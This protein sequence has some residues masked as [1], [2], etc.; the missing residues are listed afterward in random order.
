MVA[1]MALMQALFV[2]HYAKIQIRNQVSTYIRI[3]DG[4]MKHTYSNFL[5]SKGSFVRFFWMYIGLPYTT[6]SP[7]KVIG[8]SWNHF[9]SGLPGDP[10]GSICLCYEL[11]MINDSSFSS[12]TILVAFTYQFSLPFQ[13]QA[14]SKVYQTRKND[15]L[16]HHNTSIVLAHLGARNER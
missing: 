9:C 12:S 7:T 1:L 8:F 15:Q 5:Q 3:N 6:S 2:A 4:Q 14:G 13:L 16:F 10:D 11:V